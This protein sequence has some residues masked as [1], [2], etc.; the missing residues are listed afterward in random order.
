MHTLVKQHLAHAQ[1]RMKCQADKGRSE[2]SFAVGDMVFLKLQPYM[3]LSLARHANNKL[4]IKFF[5]PFKI[6]QKIGQVAYKLEIPSQA[7]IHP[8]FHVSQ[9]KSSARS[10]QI[11]PLMVSDLQ[12]CQ[13]PVKVLQRRWTDG[14][15]PAELGLIQWSHMLPEL[16]TWSRSSFMEPLWRKIKNFRRVLI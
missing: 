14:L 6:L 9:L 5:S 1:S 15:H 4:S 11:S 16:T 2:R 7:A 10:Q 12:A 3:Q 13:V 8:V